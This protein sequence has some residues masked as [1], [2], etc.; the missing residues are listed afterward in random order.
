M[1]QPNV[2]IK[3]DTMNTKIIANKFSTHTSVENPLTLTWLPEHTPATI[4]PA[5]G[6]LKLKSIGGAT[7]ELVKLFQYFPPNASNHQNISILNDPSISDYNAILLHSIIPIYKLTIE[8]ESMNGDGICIFLFNQNGEY[9]RLENAN[10][11]TMDSNQN[12]ALEQT[13]EFSEAVGYVLLGGKNAAAY[14]NMINC[15]SRYKSRAVQPA[16]SIEKNETEVV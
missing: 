5:V 7:Q 13:F 6:T 2:L 12:W 9:L 16:G 11:T 10:F 1:R 3:G 15:F 14:I 8:A 4:K